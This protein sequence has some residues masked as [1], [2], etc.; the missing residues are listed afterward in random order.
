MY[1]KQLNLTNIEFNDENINLLNELSNL[2][3]KLSDNSIDRDSVTNSDNQ[4]HP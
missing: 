2:N 3:D 1:E 4:D